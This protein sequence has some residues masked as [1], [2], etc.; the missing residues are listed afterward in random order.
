MKRGKGTEGGKRRR[1]KR[2]G[3]GR[4]ESRGKIGGRRGGKGRSK[5]RVDAEENAGERSKMSGSGAGIW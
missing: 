1:E 2:E 4:E 3:R 5:R